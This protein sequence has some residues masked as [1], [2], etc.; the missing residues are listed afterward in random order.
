MT[1]DELDFALALTEKHGRIIAN[2]ART[3]AQ[4]N[5]THS[6]DT[7]AY[8]QFLDAC[9]LLQQI[10][11]EQPKMFTLE[12]LKFCFNTVRLF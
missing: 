4:T 7:K 1:T 9:S 2:K 10:S 3:E 6:R 8:K 11:V 5:F 12:H